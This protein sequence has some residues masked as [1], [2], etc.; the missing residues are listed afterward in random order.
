MQT[1][2]TGPR[3]ASGSGSE[4]EGE[5]IER[6]TEFTGGA[7]RLG[8]DLT[9]GPNEG[10]MK[11]IYKRGW[12]G[13]YVFSV[14]QTMCAPR[15]GLGDPLCVQLQPAREKKCYRVAVA[16]DYRGRQVAGG[17][18]PSL[19]GTECCG[20]N[21]GTGGLD[22]AERCSRSL[23]RC[24]GHW[25]GKT[26]VMPSAGCRGVGGEAKGC[27]GWGREAVARGGGFDPVLITRWGAS[28]SSVL[29]CNFEMVQEEREI[30]TG[31]G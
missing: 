3:D 5:C 30:T 6:E 24:R 22:F 31:E 10:G 13:L 15:W 29:C 25:Q 26:G 21:T 11:P 17:G 4:A 14:V 28:T 27:G 16:G 12:G 1:V 9:G 20:T 23:L 7:S 18:A 8:G 2:T 19:R